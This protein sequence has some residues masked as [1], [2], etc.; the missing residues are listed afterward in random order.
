ML[1]LRPIEQVAVAAASPNLALISLIPQGHGAG[2]GTTALTGQVAT[3]P[4][5]TKL[6]RQKTFQDRVDFETVFREPI[7]GTPWLRLHP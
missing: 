3:Y 4:V 1:T 5:D 2:R 6:T 7:L